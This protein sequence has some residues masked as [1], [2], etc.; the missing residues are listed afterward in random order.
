E[1]LS[2]RQ[3]AA[4]V[5]GVVKDAFILWLNQNVQAA[6]LLAEMA[7]SS[8]QRR[9]RAAKKV[10]RK[11]LTSGPALPGKLADCTAQDLNRTELFLVEGDSAGGSAKQARDR[12]YQAIMPLKGKILNTWEVSSD[13]VLA[14]QEVHDISV[15]I[16]IDPDS[17][18]LS[19]LRYGKICILADADSDGLHIATL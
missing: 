9:M 16:G 3:C 1:R 13:E 15:A 8:A 5:S 11:K 6:E 12:E 18:D 7:I 17:D 14:S 4:F 10:V 2:S 19:Q